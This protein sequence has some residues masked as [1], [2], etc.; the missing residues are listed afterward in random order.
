[1]ANDADY[2]QRTADPVDDKYDV[3][4]MV[5]ALR[6]QNP[7]LSL[8]SNETEMK[9]FEDGLRD[10]LAGRG[11]TDRDQALLRQGRPGE[12]EDEKGDMEYMDGQDGA[13]RWRDRTKL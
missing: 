8:W 3:K 5:A 13:N 6:R 11:T 4:G 12:V 7:Y 9:R 1:M 10:N 2:S